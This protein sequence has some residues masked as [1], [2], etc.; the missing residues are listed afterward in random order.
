MKCNMTLYS[1]CSFTFQG[2]ENIKPGL[3]KR[4]NTTQETYQQSELTSEFSSTAANTN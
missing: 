4:I 1:S 2:K 3:S